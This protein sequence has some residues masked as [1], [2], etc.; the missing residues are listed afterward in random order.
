MTI[1]LIAAMLGVSPSFA[2]EEPNNNSESVTGKDLPALGEIP[3][4]KTLGDLIKEYK[5]R[6]YE[7]QAYWGNE[8]LGM[9]PEQ[10]HDIRTGLDHVYKREYSKARD[11][12]EE[13]DTKW[14]GTPMSAAID[15]MI[16]QALMLENF[17]YKYEDQWEVSSRRAREDLTTALKNDGNQ[18]F[19]HFMLA[20][21]IG[22][23]SIHTM[24]KAKYLPALQLA[25]E[26]MDE[27][28]KSRALAPNFTDLKLADGM[29]NYW[30][31]AITMTTPILPDYGD[32]RI[33]GIQQM[34]EV[35]SAG[36]FLAPAATLS[37]VFTWLEEHDNKR[38]LQACLRN[39]RAYPD[40]VINNQVLGQ[41]YTYT[42]KFELA[43]GAFERILEVDPKNKRVHYWLGV[44]QMRAGKSD[45]AEKSLNTYLGFDYLEDW[46]RAAALYRLGQVFNRRRDFGQAEKYYKMA[47]KVNG[48]KGAKANLDRLKKRKKEGKIDY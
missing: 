43:I 45:E 11:H 37:M 17:D 33:E 24:R 8:Q 36:V 2:Q 7:P 13:L 22:I 14:P 3:E 38:A 23:E 19:E 44:A 18:A 9:E 26:A 40:S 35:E 47:V 21:I 15:A 1:L 34:Q 46:Q 42:R 16:W 6:P 12:F 5:D 31:T 32:H 27:A 41:T 30:R 28:E 29:Y 4:G 10:V 20:G 39:Q 48:H 25:F